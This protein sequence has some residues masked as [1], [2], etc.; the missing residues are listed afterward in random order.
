MTLLRNAALSSG[1]QYVEAV[2]GIATGVLIARTLGPEHYGYYAF[3]VWL[4]GWM[5]LA[6]NNGL[7]LSAIRFVAEFRG[8]RQTE[9][10][11][12]LGP[13]LL[14]WQTLCTAVVV[15]IFVAVAWVVAPQEWSE[16][17]YWMIALVVLA[18]VA[19]ARFWMLASIGKGFE[20]FEPECYS[21]LVMVAANLIALGLWW[22]FD[23]SVVTA[24]GIYAATGLL[25]CLVAQRLIRTCGIKMRAGAIEPA[26]RA[27]VV[28]TVFSSGVMISIGLLSSRTLE[29][30][31]LK[32]F[33][34]PETIAYFVIAAT[35]TKGAV[36]LLTTGLASVLLPAMSRAFGRSGQARAGSIMAESIR[37][38]WFIGL[39]IAGIGIVVTRGA[40]TLLYGVNY[41]A[42]IPAVT[43][44]LVIA[45]LA[46]F[47]GAFNAFQIASNL[48]V[49]QIW[50]AVATLGVNVI[51]AVALVPVWGLTGAIISMAITRAVSVLI[52]FF[53]VR[54][55][56]RV[57]I[58]WEVLF[59]LLFS[60]LVACELGIVVETLLAS[61][62]SFVASACIF[63]T[64]FLVISVL[65]RSWY[66][67][68]YALATELA[69]RLGPLGQR[70]AVV[71]RR[72]GRRYAI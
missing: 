34:S 25:C 44:M 42:A 30:G 32:T 45:G 13:T 23:R 71:C 61:R 19:R 47:A 28:R 15:A 21:I 57:R 48:Q 5:I 55:R 43:A 10:V 49:D 63:V 2:I 35:L 22:R 66:S 50:T 16:H 9:V 67:R 52:Q 68:D 59:R 51:A 3:A 7:T 27:R 12:A 56:I 20:R 41:E 33:W 11:D 65:M 37:Y 58:K 6:A 62:F 31:L 29:I 38:Y 40:V 14:R 4:C 64:G 1:V 18:V 26:T 36:D 8:A 53:M 70:L 17:R 46:S 72:V 39:L 24:F 69:A 54:K 60:A